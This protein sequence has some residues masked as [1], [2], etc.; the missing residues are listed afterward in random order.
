MLSGMMLSILVLISSRERQFLAREFL[1]LFDNVAGDAEG[2]QNDRDAGYDRQGYFS[3][4]SMFGH[5]IRSYERKAIEYDRIRPAR[6]TG[7]TP[8]RSW[9]P[10]S[11]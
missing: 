6:L 5:E 2:Q 8:E 7:Q 1:M 9:S 11:S 3:Q 10:S 4:A